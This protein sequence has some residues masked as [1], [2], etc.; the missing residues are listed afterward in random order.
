[1]EEIKT[2]KVNFGI[3]LSQNFQKVTL[4]IAEEPIEYSSDEEF[5]AKIRQKYT[6]LR[7]ECTKELAKNI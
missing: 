5:R 2:T 1:M 6:L 4:E 7:E 3:S